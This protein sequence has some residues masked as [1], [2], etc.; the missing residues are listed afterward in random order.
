MSERMSTREWGG[1]GGFERVETSPRRDAGTGQTRR[2]LW[3]GHGLWM[4]RDASAVA[5]LPPRASARPRCGCTKI[6]TT[7]PPWVAGLL[8]TAGFEGFAAAA[9]AAAVAAA[10]VAVGRWWL[11]RAP[12]CGGG[13]GVHARV[14]A[15]DKTTLRGQVWRA[16][17][18]NCP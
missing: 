12:Y 7:T 4:R 11:W 5:T 6:G 15:R 16:C 2:P 8:R 10:A 17:A 13:C 1:K 9:S 14:T 3:R 18:S